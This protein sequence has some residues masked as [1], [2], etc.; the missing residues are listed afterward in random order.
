MS[1]VAVAD[2]DGDGDA[3]PMVPL[4]LLGSYSHVGVFTNRSGLDDILFD[5]VAAAPTTGTGGYAFTV[6]VGDLD[7]DGDADVVA[8]HAIPG[9][10]TALDN[11]TVP[12]AAG[13]DGVI[14]FE[15]P[16]TVANDNFFRH[17]AVVDID[18]DCD[19]DV[20]AL[21]LISNAIWVLSNHTPQ[22][23]GCG[24]GTPRLAGGMPP[25]PATRP[26]RVDADLI[27]DL[28]GDGVRSGADVALWLSRV[29][30]ASVDEGAVRP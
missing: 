5:R 3:D 18:G 16:Q 24:E 28:D 4:I 23:N 2:L 25:V 27:G 8:G 21:D 7:G 14:A 15:S 29:G 26:L 9:P 12:V 30:G 22:E 19:L 17:V 1:S 10:L 13:G 6:G 20:L 11:R